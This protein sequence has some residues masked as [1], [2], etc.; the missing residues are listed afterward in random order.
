[1]T[2]VARPATH[3]APITIDVA[4]N[5]AFVPDPNQQPTKPFPLQPHQ[6]S[7]IQGPLYLEGGVLEGVDRSLK[8]PVVLPFEEDAP[9]EPVADG[10]TNENET[11]DRVVVFNDTSFA[12]DLGSLVRQHPLPSLLV[13]FGVG[14]LLG[15]ALRRESWPTVFPP[16]RPPRSPRW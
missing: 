11:T 12:D 2:L 13:V 16:K 1:M 6:A 7:R 14:F 15:S 3:T 5:P 10:T 8:A 9:P 4:A